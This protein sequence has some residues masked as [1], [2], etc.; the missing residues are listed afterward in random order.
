ME[1]VIPTYT[2]EHRRAE[3]Q[4][5][6]EPELETPSLGAQAREVVVFL[7]EVDKFL[8]R[9]EAA[10]GGPRGSATAGGGKV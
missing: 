4:G 10:L 5:I 2:G 1:R 8:E 6:P 7:K 3:Y 9:I